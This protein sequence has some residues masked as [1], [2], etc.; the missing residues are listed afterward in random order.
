MRYFLKASAAVALCAALPVFAQDD[1]QSSSGTA[2]AQMEQFGDMMGGLFQAEPLT[3]EQEARLPHAEAIVGTMMPDGFYTEMM[4]GMMD[5][6]MRPMM[7]AFAT[8]E[9]VLNARLA[10]E[11]EAIASLGEAEQLEVMTMLDPAFDRRVDAIVAVLTG[12]MGG[13]FSAME[14][15]M[16][17]GLSRAYAVRFDDRQLA[18]I[19]G[20]FRTPSGSAYARESMALFFDPQVMQASMQA[21]PAMMS[22]FGDIETAMKEAMDALP[23]ERGY[24]DLSGRERARMAE[25]LGVEASDL[26]EIVTPPRPID[27][28]GG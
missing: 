26:A 23:P 7:S 14:E 16:R 5:E 2:Q 1:A 11:E 12:R 13:M 20:F 21:L 19:A 8:P 22:G 9:F 10:V 27:E 25:L 15:P 24:D 4:R 17:E 18:D 3:A 28:S 6:M